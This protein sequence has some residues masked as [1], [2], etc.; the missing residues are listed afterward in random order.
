[1]AQKDLKTL[2]P[3]GPG[4]VTSATERI[5]LGICWA[6]FFLPFFPFLNTISIGDYI[7]MIQNEAIG[8]TCFI[9]C[10]SSTSNLEWEDKFKCLISISIVYIEHQHPSRCWVTTT[11]G[12]RYV[13]LP[14]LCLAVWSKRL[15]LNTSIWKNDPCFILKVFYCVSTW[16][17]LTLPS[18][19]S[20]P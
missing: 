17:L 10:T 7:W 1:M 18:I 8:V 9:N 6:Q 3:T 4:L 11:S 2:Y 14:I 15:L 20:V 5:H 12:H 19:F 13:L 16:F